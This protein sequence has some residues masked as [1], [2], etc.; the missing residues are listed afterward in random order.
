[1][2]APALRAAALL[3]A[4]VASCGPYAEV[5]QKLDVT[6]PFAD[7]DTW[8]AARGTEIRLLV[9]GRREAGA[10]PAFALTVLQTPVSA[11]VSARALQG[12]FTEDPASS[13]ATFT[14]RR[15]YLL[16]DERDKPLLGRTGATRRDVNR[17]AHVGFERSGGGLVVS[18]DDELA[19]AYRPLAEAIAQ[20]GAATERDAACGFQVANLGI[21]A[22]QV[23]IIGFGGPGM[24]QYQNKATYNATVSGSFTVEL[25]GFLDNR[26]TIRFA[27]VVELTGVRLDGPQI[28]EA[29]SS[30]D[31]RMSGVL[32]FVLSPRGPDGAALPVI[33]GALDYGGAGD[34][35]DAIRIERGSAVG[36]H[37]AIAL[38]GGGTAR[39]S[40]ET[41]PSPSLAECLTL[42]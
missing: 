42:P 16:A 40:P 38:D 23:R 10:A 33:S 7:A 25:E 18:G 13:A 31:G 17:V 37:Y 21:R 41:S 27:D 2:S 5:A 11:G 26:T 22:T 3:G 8:V 19:G 9:L 4:L 35:A 28:T 34:P 32:A 20:L 36:G 30:G 6:A 15:E 1:V 12:D 39:V 29:D 14:A 24:T